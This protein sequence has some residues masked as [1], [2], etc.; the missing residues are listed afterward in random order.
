LARKGCFEKE[1]EKD[2]GQNWPKLGLRGNIEFTHKLHILFS[3]KMNK[4]GGREK[5]LLEHKL[6]GRGTFFFSKV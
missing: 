6:R 3:A 4:K 1:G 2:F 5:E